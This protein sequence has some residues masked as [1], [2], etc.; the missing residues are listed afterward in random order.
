MKKIILLLIFIAFLFPIACGKH[1]STAPLSDE[2]SKLTKNERVRILI[3]YYADSELKP[4]S[5]LMQ[6]EIE[7]E[8]RLI[9]KCPI[10][11]PRYDDAGQMTGF[12]V[13]APKIRFSIRKKIS[14][15][16]YDVNVAFGL[17]DNVHSLLN[18][19]Y[20]EY[21]SKGYASLRVQ[22][23]GYIDAELEDGFSKKMPVFYELKE[24]GVFTMRNR[25]VELLRLKNK[26]KDGAETVE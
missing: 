22:P 26:T 11:L 19:Y 20:T 16:V 9:A 10:V 23:G 7:D 5:E 1:E 12:Q 18:T 15:G 14:E 2:T 24:K 21:K 25:Y 3:D 13:N 17:G 6:S 8:I 4:V